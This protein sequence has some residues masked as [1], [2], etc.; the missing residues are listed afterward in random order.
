M[1][2]VISQSMYFPWVGMLEQIRLADIFVHYDDVQFTRGYFNRIQIKSAAGQK[3]LTIPIRKHSQSSHINSIL[4][5]QSRDWKEEHRAELAACYKY[6]PYYH[7]LLSI[8]DETFTPSHET[9]ADVARASMLS[10]AKYF[11]IDGQRSFL[12]SAKLETEGRSSERLL[13]ICQKLGAT[14]YITGHG[15]RNYLDHCLFSSAGISVTYMNYAKEPYP[16]RF[17]EF[18]P[19]VTGLDLVANCGREGIKYIKS[20]TVPWKEITDGSD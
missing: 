3:W 11:G 12:E 2:I 10:L 14:S 17:G 18:T 16:Q 8:V 19:Y 15:A 6:C 5:D 9:L 20:G 4:L 13:R 7:D 1:R